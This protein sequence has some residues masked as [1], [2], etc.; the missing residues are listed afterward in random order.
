MDSF[1]AVKTCPNLLQSCSRCAHLKHRCAMATGVTRCERC[2]RDKGTCSFRAMALHE[3]LAKIYSL[4]FLQHNWALARPERFALGATPSTNQS[5]AAGR[6]K[7]IYPVVSP[8][9]SLLDP[10]TSPSPSPLNSSTSPKQIDLSDEE[11]VENWLTAGESGKG[12]AEL[13]S[14]VNISVGLSPNLLNKVEGDLATSRETSGQG[15]LNE[16]AL[17]ELL[18]L[19]GDERRW[20]AFQAGQSHFL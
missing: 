6:A 16:E 14:N 15:G 18:G 11:Q 13:T 10:P 19:L 9:P 2:I 20:H 3:N 12:E 5:R 7:D 1:I 17:Q 8:S 4:Q